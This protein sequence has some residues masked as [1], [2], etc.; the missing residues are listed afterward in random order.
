MSLKSPIQFSGFDYGKFHPSLQ[1]IFDSSIGN[2]GAYRVVTP[3]DLA[4]TV[5][6]SG[7][8]L[9]V[10]IGENIGVTGT[11]NSFII[12]PIAVSGGNVSI[13]GTV[14]STIVGGS[15][16]VNITGNS[17]PA[18][19]LNYSTS[20]VSTLPVQFNTI[21][22][23]IPSGAAQTVFTLSSGTAGFIRNLDVNPLY[24]KF[25]AFANSTSFS[26]IL[27]GGSVTGDGK[28]G[29]ITIDSW[30]GA[31]SVSGSNSYLAYTLR[32]Q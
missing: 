11:V 18:A 26:D 27:F 19:T 9:T 17:A 20:S 31:V 10:D 13:T 14:N 25:G 21:N 7:Q 30:F 3:S 23:F 15:V 8:N 32:S 22:N 28:G 1:Y 29:F 16:N 6:I 2:G 4:S 24:V 5:N 12:N